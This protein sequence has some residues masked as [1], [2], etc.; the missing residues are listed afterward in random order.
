MSS[1]NTY[2]LTWVSL[3][4]DTLLGVSPHGCSSKAQPLLLTLDEGYLLTATPLDLERGIAPLSSPETSLSKT[5]IQFSADWWSCTPPSVSCLACCNPALGS[6]GSM[7]GLMVTSNRTYTKGNFQD[8]CCHC[9]SPCGEP[10]LSHASTGDPLT[11]AN[12]C[13]SVSCGVTAPFPWVLVHEI[14]CLCPPRVESLF[15]SVLWNSHN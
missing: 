3:T 10:L 11:L 14:F 13:G 5:L 9:P 4:L 12:R 15:L 8:C 2:H 1:H 6:M 7:V